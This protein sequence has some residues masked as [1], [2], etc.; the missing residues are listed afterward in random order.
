MQHRMTRKMLTDRNILEHLLYLPCLLGGQRPADKND[1]C[2]LNYSKFFD[3]ETFIPYHF[4]LVRLTGL[5]KDPALAAKAAKIASTHIYDLPQL[6]EMWL[7]KRAHGLE[8]VGDAEIRLAF[9]R[10]DAA[11]LPQNYD[12]TAAKL[13]QLL[14]GPAWATPSRLRKSMPIPG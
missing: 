5:D 3:L 10:L 1:R 9:A 11:M 12:S 2:E 7:V 4:R 6:L 14:K 8:T 13:R